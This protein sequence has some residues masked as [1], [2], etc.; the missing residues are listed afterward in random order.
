MLLHTIGTVALFPTCPLNLFCENKPPQSLHWGIFYCRAHSMLCASKKH[1]TILAAVAVFVSLVL[2]VLLNIFFYPLY[3]FIYFFFPF[4]FAFA[5]APQPPF[6]GGAVL[7]FSSNSHA[8]TRS[9]SAISNRFGTE[10]L[11]IPSVMYGP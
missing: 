9:M 1:Y 2:L 7:F 10:T 8:V 3:A 5:F 4:G 6:R 11:V